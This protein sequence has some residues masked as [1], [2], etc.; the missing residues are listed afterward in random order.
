MSQYSGFLMRDTLEDDGRV[1]SPGYPY[2]SPDVISHV[3][4]ANPTAFFTGNYS[5]DPN[6]P[7][8]AGSRLNPVYV[9]AKNLSSQPLNG[10]YISVFRAAPTLFLRPSVWKNNPLRTA[11]G[12]TSVALPATVAPGAVGV[13]QD[14]FM[15]D[16]TANNLYCCVGIV[17][18]TKRVVV[19]ADF[20]DYA[21]YITWVRNNQNVCGRNLSVIRD[22]PNRSYEQLK[23]FSNPSSSESVPTMFVVTVIGTLPSGTTFGIQCAPLGISESWNISGGKLRTASGMTPPL[24]NGTVTTWA[25]LPPNHTWPPGA[26]INTE[27]FVGQRSDGPTAQ[28]ATP[29]EQLRVRRDEIPGLGDGVLVRLGNCQTLFVSG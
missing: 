29:L 15:L 1:P 7:V 21:S 19:P 16:A 11:S 13:G 23:S 25:L 3:Q 20:P 28:Y 26:R 5:S 12:E 6:Q 22:Y 2:S 4:V 17:S 8:Q 9:R 18:A 14:V 27:A 10:H 24:F